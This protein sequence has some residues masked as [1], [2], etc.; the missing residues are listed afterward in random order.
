VVKLWEGNWEK[1]TPFLTFDVTWKVVSAFLHGD[2]LT[3][4][5]DPD[6][7]LLP[8]D[9]AAT[10]AADPAGSPS[11]PPLTHASRWRARAGR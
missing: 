6:L 2:R 8:G 11:C 4:V 5:A 1:F 10:A 3:G 7:D 9:T